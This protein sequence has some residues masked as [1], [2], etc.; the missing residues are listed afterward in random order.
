MT[1]I[2]FMDDLVQKSFYG[3]GLLAKHEQRLPCFAGRAIY[4]HVHVSG[5]WDHSRVHM[6]LV[7]GLCK[8][9]NTFSKTLNSKDG[10][11]QCIQMQVHWDCSENAFHLESEEKR[12]VYMYFAWACLSDPCFTDHLLF[13]TSFTAPIKG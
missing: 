13:K 7:V 11:C 12:S 6:Y 8:L 3:E 5:V 2:P 9:G 1:E 4:L 10:R